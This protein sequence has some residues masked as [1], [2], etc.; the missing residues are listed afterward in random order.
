MNIFGLCQRAYVCVRVLSYVGSFV[1]LR[2]LRGFDLTLA[3]PTSRVGSRVQDLTDMYVRA[4]GRITAK[5]KLLP[6][7]A[8]A[9]IALP[10][11]NGARLS[12]C[13]QGSKFLRAGK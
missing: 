13:V 9:G 12:L 7:T 2:A 5:Q 4:I 1:L 6:S 10:E 3:L 11:M 8:P